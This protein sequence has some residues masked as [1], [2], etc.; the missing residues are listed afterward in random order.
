[1]AAHKLIYR[2]VVLD[3]DAVN[4]RLRL[5]RKRPVDDWAPDHIIGRLH[6]QG[7]LERFFTSHD[8]CSATKTWHQY[9]VAVS[10]SGAALFL[11]Q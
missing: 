9:Q 11:G 1:M 4:W 2:F 10:Q 5:G 7:L 8:L 3:C 6:R